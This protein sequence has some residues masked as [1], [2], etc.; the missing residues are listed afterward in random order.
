MET[1]QGMRLLSASMMLTL[2]DDPHRASY[3]FR[4]HLEST[5]GDTTR[6]WTYHLPSE[7]ADVT[8]LRAW[9]EAGELQACGLPGPDR[10]S[11]LNV[12]LR[13]PLCRR[14]RYAFGFAFESS[15]QPVIAPSP[16]RPIITVADSVV[17]SLP[18][19][20][21]DITVVLPSAAALVASVPGFPEA[22]AGRFTYRLRALR[23]RETAS[24]LVAYRRAAPRRP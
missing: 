16:R 1:I 5:G 20:V 12:R 4:C 2:L 22:Q 10:T 15:V 21:L 6:Y 14:E 19:A 3:E 9:D 13:D 8:D 23:P 17:Y 24:F 7:A 18:C 11:R